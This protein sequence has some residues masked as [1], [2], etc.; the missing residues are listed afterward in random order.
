[1]KNSRFHLVKDR[2]RTVPFNF[3]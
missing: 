1:M 3:F 2:Q